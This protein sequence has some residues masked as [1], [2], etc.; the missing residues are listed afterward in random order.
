MDIAIRIG[1][2]L[3]LSFAMVSAAGCAT[4][5]PMMDLLTGG[6]AKREAAER[7]AAAA[8][9][10]ERLDALERE[11]REAELVENLR[12]GHE[13][14]A[15]IRAEKEARDAARAAARQCAVALVTGLF[16]GDPDYLHPLAWAGIPESAVREM[17]SDGSRLRCGRQYDGI[18]QQ[19]VGVCDGCIWL[20]GANWKRPRMPITNAPFES[21]V[22]YAV[23]Y[24]EIRVTLQSGAV[25]DASLLGRPTEYQC[26]RWE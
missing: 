24:G 21:P 5:S 1:A 11:R 16:C 18:R 23:Y 15:E 8:A 13:K 3:L 10:R 12:R 19:V 14:A 9:E 7:E 25:I 20:D 4:S 22:P 2:T 6:E 17:L 26:L